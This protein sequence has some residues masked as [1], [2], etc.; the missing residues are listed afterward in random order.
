MEER[1]FAVLRKGVQEVDRSK[2]QAH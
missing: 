2:W 1:G